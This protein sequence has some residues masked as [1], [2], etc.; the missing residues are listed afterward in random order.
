[1]IKNPQLHIQR[2]KMGA[3]TPSSY[4]YRS[5]PR[6]AGRWTAPL[7]SSW[8]PWHFSALPSN[9]HH[10]QPSLSPGS[11][12]GRPQGPPPAAKRAQPEFSP[13]WW[14]VE[15]RGRS[16]GENRGGPRGL[17]E[18]VFFCWNGNLLLLLFP[19]DYSLIKD[20]QFDSGIWAL[21]W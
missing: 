4:L 1:M 5:C 14:K 6:S 17:W 16:R 13:F 21:K 7:G 9:S 11:H 2:Q 18:S 20:F 15:R 3:G 19:P 10:S 12:Q 8:Q